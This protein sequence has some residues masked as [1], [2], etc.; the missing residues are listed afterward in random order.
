[1]EL[2]HFLSEAIDGVDNIINECRKLFS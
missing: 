2:D 1:M